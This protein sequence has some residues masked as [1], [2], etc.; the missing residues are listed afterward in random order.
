MSVLVNN[1]SYNNEA[2]RKQRALLLENLCIP[3]NPVIMYT[4][5]NS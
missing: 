1:A 2:A 3:M 5:L 4:Q